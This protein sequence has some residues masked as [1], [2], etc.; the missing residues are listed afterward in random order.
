MEQNERVERPFMMASLDRC[1]ISNVSSRLSQPYERRIPLGSQSRLQHQPWITTL[2]STRNT[3]LKFPFIH[4]NY[5]KIVYASGWS[6]D[7]EM[8]LTIIHYHT[9]SNQP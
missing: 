5:S 4:F 9:K 7:T 6:Y 1:E 8:W 3:Y 2:N